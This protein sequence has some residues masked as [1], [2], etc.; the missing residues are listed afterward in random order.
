MAWDVIETEVG[1]RHVIPQRDL[2][3]H[4]ESCQCWCK[5]TDD[6]G[7]WVHNSMDRREFVER[8]E[9]RKH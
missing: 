9:T 8:G 4:A 1:E 7:V 6:D 2:K 5:P 3:P